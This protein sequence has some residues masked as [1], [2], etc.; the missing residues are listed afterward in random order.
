M[1]STEKDRKCHEREEKKKGK[2][3]QGRRQLL[4]TPYWSMGSIL[5]RKVGTK[6]GCTLKHFALAA[7][8]SDSLALY[9]LQR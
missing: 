9:D 5:T 8:S 1:G 2:G 3:I 6:P 7:A 4:Q